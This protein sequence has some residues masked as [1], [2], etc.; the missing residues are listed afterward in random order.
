MRFSTEA[1]PLFSGLKDATDDNR[2]KANEFAANLKAAGGN[3]H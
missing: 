1:E 2:K 3:G